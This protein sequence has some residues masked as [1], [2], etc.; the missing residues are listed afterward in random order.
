MSVSLTSEATALLYSWHSSV[1]ASTLIP[2]ACPAVATSIA[3]TTHR[4]GMTSVL[5]AARVGS[6]NDTPGTTV[7][8]TPRADAIWR[9]SFTEFSAT[10]GSPGTAYTMRLCLSSFLTT[11][12]SSP[13]SSTK[14]E[15]ASPA[16]RDAPGTSATEVRATVSAMVRSSS[17]MA[18]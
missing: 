16:S 17:A 15:K 2:T 14:L 1:G 8:F 12:S 5:S 13:S 9:S 7:T 11:T 18:G 10:H 3:S 4:L 6:R